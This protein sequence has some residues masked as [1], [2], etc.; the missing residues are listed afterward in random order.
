MKKYNIFLFVLILILSSCQDKSS[1]SVN[2]M[3]SNDIERFAKPSKSK[4][5][6]Y[7]EQAQKAIKVHENDYVT[8]VISLLN[9]ALIESD[10][11]NKTGEIC[12]ELI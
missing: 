7:Y 2:H 1:Q 10:D 9:E 8:N 4:C 3:I 12:L 11:I 6:E 5:I